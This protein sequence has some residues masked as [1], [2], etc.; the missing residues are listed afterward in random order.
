MKPQWA[1]GRSFDRAP[2]SNR[3]SHFYV[4]ALLI[5]TAV[6]MTSDRLYASPAAV[7]LAGLA[8][9]VAVS[10]ACTRPRGHRAARPFAPEARSDR[11][12]IEGAELDLADESP[13]HRSIVRIVSAEAL[14]EPPGRAV[15]RARAVLM[16]LVSVGTATAVVLWFT[17][18]PAW[19]AAAFAAI[20]TA[21]LP[22]LAGDTT[23]RNDTH[24][25]SRPAVIRE[26]SAMHFTADPK[27]QTKARVDDASSEGSGANRRR[28]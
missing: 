15:G 4:F 1:A 23:E 9:A 27:A 2:A 19:A 22:L 25:R 18:P 17:I 26:C 28:I 13:T 10:Y 12:P 24:P 8:A 14:G 7:V 6:A 16:V 11:T 3:R 21:I 20:A 5:A